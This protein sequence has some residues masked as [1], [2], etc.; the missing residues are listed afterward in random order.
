MLLI[1]LAASTWLLP[2]AGISWF[3]LLAIGLAEIL[4]QPLF[5]LM[6]SEHH[7]LGH[8]AQAK[9][10]QV[11]PLFLR[12]VAALTIYMLHWGHP[13]AGYAVGYFLATILSLALGASLLPSSWPRMR[14]WQLA[15]K[16]R[17]QEAAGYAVLNITQAGP[18]ELDK[19]LATRLL[20]LGAAGVYAAGARVIGA[21]TLP[22]IA[23]MVSALPRLFR[24]SDNPLQD[25]GRLL[26]WIFGSAGAYSL[27][28]VI[29]LW[30]L[31]PAFN[32]IFGASY[33]SIDQVIRMLCLAIPGMAFRI[34]AGD[35]LMAMGKPW[36][37]VGFEAC[38]LFVLVLAAILLT[39][40][41]GINGMTVALASSEWA[42]ACTGCLM[43]RHAA[44]R[45]RIRS[46]PV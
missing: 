8:V 44:S 46:V 14:S 21:T 39:R 10:M 17:L 37:R 29:I 43:V 41:Y 18:A 45:L 1:F 25:T 24:E 9:L 12:F 35:I 3:T 20:P 5:G 28:L 38:G 23:L 36:M 16:S 2:S 13:L 15:D 22:V 33:Q 6:T 42:M 34:C 31:A 11:F 26:R 32:W 7:G 40:N 27:F 4:L 19:T 30:C